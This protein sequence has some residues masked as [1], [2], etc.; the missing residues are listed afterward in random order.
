MP[1]VDPALRL[2]R[3]R[4]CGRPERADGRV[5]RFEVVEDEVE[6]VGFVEREHGVAAGDVH[7]C[8]DD[9][10]VRSDWYVEPVSSLLLYFLKR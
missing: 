5:F 9:L 2:A 4:S 7:G 10:E 3:V 8:G 1:H 6:E